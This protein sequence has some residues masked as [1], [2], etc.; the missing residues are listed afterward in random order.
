MK[1]IYG[2]LAIGVSAVSLASC[3]DDVKT[4]SDGA[5]VAYSIDESNKLVNRATVTV[6]NNSFN[7]EYDAF[8]TLT[9][10]D[11][12][13]QKY[14]DAIGTFMYIQVNHGG[15]SESTE[16]VFK[17]LEISGVLYT[18]NETT[19]TDAWTSDNTVTL[20]S[21]YVSTSNG[22]LADYE[23]AVMSDITAAQAYIDAYEAGEIKVLSDDDNDENTLSM[24]VTGI[25]G[26]L[27]KSHADSTYWPSEE[28][29][30]GW[31]ANIDAIE[32]AF[33]SD[34][35]LFDVDFTGTLENIVLGSATVNSVYV[36]ADL[37]TIAYDNYLSSLE[38]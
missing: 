35:S 10:A 15:Y 13:N 21:G 4:Y 19:Y 26:N 37:I 18:F 23:E 5:G 31:K 16:N 20:A 22:S 36:Y 38:A 11:I 1:R 32:G 29:G 17:Y 30:L 28:G 2:L 6:A 8:M 27:N 34:P 24:V 33:E 14:Y 25:K 7:V 9:S 12:Y 3:G